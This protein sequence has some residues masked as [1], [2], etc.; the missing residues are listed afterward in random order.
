VLQGPL[1]AGVC[2]GAV[3]AVPWGTRHGSQPVL[4]QALVPCKDI[5]QCH[6]AVQHHPP[7]PHL[8][9]RPCAL[10]AGLRNKLSRLWKANQEGAASDAPYPW[11]SVESQMRQVGD[12]GFLLGQYA[13]AAATYRLAAGDYLNSGNNKWYAGVEVSGWRGGGW[14]AW[15]QAAGAGR[16][17]RQRSAP[18]LHPYL[19][20][21]LPACL[22]QL[23]LLA[24]LR[25]VAMP[26]DT[27]AL[28]A[29]ALPG[30]DRPVLHHGPC[31]REQR[32]PQV[33]QQGV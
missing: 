20:C 7:A 28:P 23:L 16:L 3:C 6:L 19:L 13:F 2:A 18:A 12:L 8:P 25:P 1:P 33:L 22:L 5:Q 15:G 31:Q 24:L 10:A 29:L 27:P 11:H 26:A 21:L 4:P 32:P 9:H 14:V 17:S 30:D